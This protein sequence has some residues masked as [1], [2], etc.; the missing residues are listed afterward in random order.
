MQLDVGQAA[1]GCGSLFR[2]DGGLI[3][4]LIRLSNYYEL[5]TRH[6]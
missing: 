6:S 2:L 5:T 4:N 1:A 3:G